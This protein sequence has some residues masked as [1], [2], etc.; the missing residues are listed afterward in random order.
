MKTPAEMARLLAEKFG[1]VSEGH[2]ARFPGTSGIAKAR[3][4]LH[5]WG[6]RDRYVLAFVTAWTPTQD[7][8]TAIIDEEALS[9]TFRTPLT[10]PRRTR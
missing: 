9:V 4:Q 10:S 6:Y 2:T 8:P 3:T 1:G 5:R 7:L